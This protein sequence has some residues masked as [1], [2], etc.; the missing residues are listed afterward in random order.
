MA[1]AKQINE[2][3]SKLPDSDKTSSNV[4]DSQGNARYGKATYLFVY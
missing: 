4:A 3:T 1:D 2:A